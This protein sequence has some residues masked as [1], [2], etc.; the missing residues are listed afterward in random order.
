MMG[1]FDKD[2]VPLVIWRNSS[3]RV[4]SKNQEITDG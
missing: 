4:M 1:V 3:D 2:E